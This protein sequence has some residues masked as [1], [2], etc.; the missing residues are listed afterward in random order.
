[1]Y[2][3]EQSNQFSW[4][5]G[6]SLQFLTTTTKQQQQQQ[7]QAPS[8]RQ[9]YKAGKPLS[10]HKDILSQRY[11]MLVSG[12][13]ERNPGPSNNPVG[14]PEQQCDWC[15]KKIR[16]GTTSLRCQLP[17]CDNVCHAQNQISRYKATKS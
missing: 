10:F 4:T 6:T 12:D 7:Q 11:L 1:L 17:F 15:T 13:V 14:E 9:K 8:T 5:P 16:R 3:V 2:L